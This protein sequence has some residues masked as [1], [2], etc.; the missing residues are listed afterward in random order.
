MFDIPT[1]HIMVGSKRGMV[2]VAAACLSA[3]AILVAGCT[4]ERAA[5]PSPKWSFVRGERTRVGPSPRTR[6]VARKTTLGNRQSR[7]FPPVRLTSSHQQLCRVGVGD[8][9]PDL[10]LPRLG[11]GT[12]RLAELYGER[13]TVVV[14][15]HGDRLMSAMALADLT[16]DVVQSFAHQGVGVVS[17]AVREPAGAVQATVA[18]AKADYQHLLDS[19]GQAFASVGTQKLPRTFV[20]NDSGVIV[21]FDIEYSQSTR[22]ELKQ[23]LEILAGPA[24]GGG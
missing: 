7:G 23:S 21:W 19:D 3:A 15:W 20:L 22:R 4:S 11:G 5:G 18:E 1:L 10:N 14:F 2:R 8:R 12:A 13:A 17:V 16:G 24:G 9:L 6:Y